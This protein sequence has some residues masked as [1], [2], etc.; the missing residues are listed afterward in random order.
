MKGSNLAL[1]V[2]VILI[3]VCIGGYILIPDI[4]VSSGSSYTASTASDR[5]HDIHEQ[6]ATDYARQWQEVHDNPSHSEAELCVQAMLAA[7]AYLV[8]GEDAQYREWSETVKRECPAGA[9]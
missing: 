2:G 8:A 7:N 9:R 6:V 5:M 3:V 4:H 1:F